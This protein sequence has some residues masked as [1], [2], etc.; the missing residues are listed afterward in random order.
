M[1]SWRAWL[2]VEAE[3]A[4]MSENRCGEPDKRRI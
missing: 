4:Q 2:D 3:A 1:P